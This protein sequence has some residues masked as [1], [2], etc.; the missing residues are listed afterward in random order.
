MGVGLGTGMDSLETVGCSG[1][2]GVV[3]H[4]LDPL[5]LEVESHVRTYGCIN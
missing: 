5:T 1:E 3:S 4:T 2:V